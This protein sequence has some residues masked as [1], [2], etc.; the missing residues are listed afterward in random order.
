MVF[1]KKR[2]E[3]IQLLSQRGLV[4]VAALGGMIYGCSGNFEVKTGDVFIGSQPSTSLQTSTSVSTISTGVQTEVAPSSQNTTSSGKKPSVVDSAS[5]ES[6]KSVSNPSDPEVATS[7]GPKPLPDVVI[8]LKHTVPLLT[9]VPLYHFKVQAPETYQYAVV[10]F[11]QQCDA[12]AFNGSWIPT[13]SDVEGLLTQSGVYSACFLGRTLDGGVQRFA[14]PIKFTWEFDGDAPSVSIANSGSLSS[15]TASQY[16]VTGL[17]SNSEEGRS[18]T[19]GGSVNG[20]AVCTQG[21]FQVLLDLSG[22]PDGPV[23]ITADLSDEAGNT[24]PQAVVTLSKTSSVPSVGLNNTGFINAANMNSYTVS[25]TC[26]PSGLTVTLGGGVS[27]TAP[28]TQGTYSV[29]LDFSGVTDGAVLITADYPQASQ[30]SVTLTKKSTIPSVTISGSQ[31]HINIALANVS[32]YTVAGTCSE[33]GLNVTIGGARTGTGPCSGG[34]YSVTLDYSAVPDGE[35]VMT[36]QLVDA[37]GNHSAPTSLTRI[38]DL[39]APTVG[40]L[41]YSGVRGSSNVTGGPSREFFNLDWTPASD[42]LD[43]SSLLQYEVRYTYSSTVINS[44]SSAKGGNLLS[45]YTAN[46][47][48]SLDVSRWGTYYTVIVKDSAGNEAFYE[49]V[50]VPQ[51][52]LGALNQVVSLG[53]NSQRKSFYDPVHKRHWFFGFTGTQI[54]GRYS[55]D[56]VNWFDGGFLS[57]DTS[58]YAV[59]YRAINGI[60]FVFLAITANDSIVVRRGQL[61]PS[62]VIFDGAVTAFSSGHSSDLYSRAT[63]GFDGNDNL[64]VGA[65]HCDSATPLESY[66]P[67]VRRSVNRGDGDLGAWE[68]MESLGPRTLKILDLILLPRGGSKMFLVTNAPQ[69]YG[70]EYDGSSW[71]AAV[72]GGLRSWTSY[73]SQG[74]TGVVRAALARGG[75]LYIGGDFTSAGGVPQTAFIAKWDGTKWNSIGLGGMLGMPTTTA[76]RFFPGSVSAL[77]FDS[78]GRLYAAGQFNHFGGINTNFIARWN[79][80][81]WLPLN[82]L[83]GLNS[84]IASYRWI[85]PNSPLITSMAIDDLDNVY[86]GGAFSSANDSGKTGIIK[87]SP[88]GST[89]SIGSLSV[90]SWWPFVVP[91]RALAWDSSTSS[92]YAGGDFTNADGS[93]AAYLAKWQGGSWSAVGSGGFNSGVHS[94]A[95]SNNVLYVGGRFTAPA[96]R[97]AKFDGTSWSA[98]GAGADATVE[99]ILID[100]TDLY[101]G[102]QFSSSPGKGIAKWD[103]TSWVGLGQG[104]SIAAP[105]AP[106]S[107]GNGGKQRPATVLTMAK[108][109]SGILYAGGAFGMAGTTP[110]TAFL[111]AWQGNTWS[112]LDTAK[113]RGMD[114]AVYAMV[115][116]NL[117]NI[118]LG[119]DFTYAGTTPANRIVKWDGTSYTTLGSGMNGTVN[120]LFWDQSSST[121]YAGGS[122]TSADGLTARGIARWNGTQWSAL[123]TGLTNGGTVYAIDVQS[124]TQVYVGGRFDSIGG[125]TDTQNI[126]RW[127]GTSWQ[128]LYSYA[129]TSL[130]GP[131]YALLRMGSDL[132]VGGAFYQGGNYNCTLWMSN[133]TYAQIN[134]TSGCGGGVTSYVYSFAKAGTD[135]YIGSSSGLRKWDG[136]T[137]SLV[138]GGPSSYDAV[139]ALHWDGS[140]LYVGGNFSTPGASVAKL[141]GT[142]WSKLGSWGLSSPWN[143]SSG[144]NNDYPQILDSVQTLLVDNSGTLWAGGILGTADGWPTGHLASFG[145]S[146]NGIGRGGIKGLSAAVDPITGSIHVA[147]A[148]PE[149][150]THMVY[151]GSSWATTSITSTKD[152]KWTNPQIGVDPQNNKVFVLYRG[153][154]NVTWAGR[155]ITG[156]VLG[157][158]NDFGTTGSTENLYT[159]MVMDEQL[160]DGLLKVLTLDYYTSP[161]RV[162]VKTAH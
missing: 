48:R 99:S 58:E 33:S 2:C 124:S 11:P 153:A 106:G 76:D 120:A 14:K 12:S 87:I 73:P 20:S 139:Y 67:R 45:P 150:I 59:V 22:V 121:L 159:N 136:T 51:L 25:G 143:T 152:A 52:P 110:G 108:A 161:R 132:Y 95:V 98:L 39:E 89:S 116:D 21:T 103:G 55:R 135:I 65:V 35:F 60:P 96:L 13:P 128:N 140:S 37:A 149:G 7:V 118:Y 125:A 70:Y 47:T 145:T 83:Y 137:M 142:T 141:T 26:H 44:L 81:V 114:G 151:S 93:G 92:L 100:G 53:N 64:W 130:G 148:Q 119:G 56:N 90:S 4:H 3:G 74:V 104:I 156:G 122:F 154:Y 40:T 17:C 155:V 72:S 41:S 66:L 18:I 23:L 43:P 54:A 62:G 34:T 5:G 31:S 50:T 88:S 71:N 24:A 160:Q 86:L 1:V 162:I 8:G 123:G 49:A 16:L 129:S 146:D 105:S 101:A 109:T 85:F 117:G 94:I 126:A 133:Y 68:A 131:V 46:K 42:N 61:S 111:A 115:K 57:S 84:T 78:L 38:K 82:A 97:I 36:A 77:A 144:S 138:S 112:A 29:S 157:S 69:L 107:A 79:G 30:A 15:S 63:L 32:A 9:K 91:V 127:N 102:G 28:C 134:G 27:G 10:K 113:G 6:E 75:D 147:R 19:L 158:A 80:H